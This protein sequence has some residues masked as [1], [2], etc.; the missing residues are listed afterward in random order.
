MQQTSLVAS[1]MI[2][3]A[4]YFGSVTTEKVP[5]IRGRGGE[6]P[7]RL[8]P[9]YSQRAGSA[10]DSRVGR[11]WKQNGPVIEYGIGRTAGNDALTYAERFPKMSMLQLAAREPGQVVLTMDLEHDRLFVSIGYTA[12]F[13][14]TGVK[15]R[16][17]LAEVMAMI[18]T[19][20]EN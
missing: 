4:L 1:V 19:Y 18:Y 3:V 13:V 14:A 8:L 16:R 17:D 20:R 12:N 15:T 10:I 6:S 9:G 7:V 5:Q 11:I 2:V